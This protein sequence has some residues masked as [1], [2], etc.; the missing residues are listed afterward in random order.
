MSVREKN[1]PLESLLVY[2]MYSLLLARRSAEKLL[3]KLTLGL[4][5]LVGSLPLLAELEHTL[6]PA[7]FKQFILHAWNPVEI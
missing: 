6:V 3:A 7:V 2:N 1:R 5:A 4:S